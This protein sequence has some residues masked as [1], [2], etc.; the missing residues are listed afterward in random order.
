[1]EKIIINF[2]DETLDCWT[3]DDLCGV[4]EDYIDK[5]IKKTY[6]INYEAIPN[7]KYEGE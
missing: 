2:P 6:Y 4:I 3:L 5:N 7:K 1:M